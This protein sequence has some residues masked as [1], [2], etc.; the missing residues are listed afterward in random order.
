MA[1][2][3]ELHPVG[4][5]EEQRPLVT[6]ALDLADLRSGRDEAVLDGFEHLQ[7]RHGQGEM[8]D[9]APTVVPLV[10]DTGIR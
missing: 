6:E 1:A 2:H 7:R 5:A 3:L 4:I 10:Y 9:G 8:V